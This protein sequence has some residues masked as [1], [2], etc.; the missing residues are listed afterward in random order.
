LLSASKQRSFTFFTA[1]TT[2]DPYDYPNCSPECPKPGAHA[3][4][5]DDDGIP[6]NYA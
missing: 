1:P 4:D 2:G 6:D 3:N 5:D